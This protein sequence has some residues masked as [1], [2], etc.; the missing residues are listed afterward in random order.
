VL[1]AGLIFRR[2]GTTGWHTHDPCCSQR[3]KHV[4][5]TRFGTHALTK[6][7]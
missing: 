5:T 7:N 4:R 1:Q 6:R 3:T 2:G